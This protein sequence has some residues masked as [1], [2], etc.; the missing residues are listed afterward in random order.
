MSSQLLLQYG[1]VED[2]V[3]CVREMFGSQVLEIDDDDISYNFSR[4]LT[5]RRDSLWL[6]IKNKIQKCG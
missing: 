6:W 1:P 2:R 3:K 5:S 4:R